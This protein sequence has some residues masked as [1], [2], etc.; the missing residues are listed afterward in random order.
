MPRAWIDQPGRPHWSKG[1]S[2]MAAPN[3]DFH[4]KAAFKKLLYSGL[5]TLLD[6]SLK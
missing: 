5:Y 2:F 3:N 4:R 6:L 1:Q